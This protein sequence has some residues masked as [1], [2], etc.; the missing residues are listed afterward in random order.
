MSDQLVDFEETL[1]IG[2]EG[3]A[4]LPEKLLEWLLYPDE[5]VM[6]R[7]AMQMQ[8]D[9]LQAERD[10]LVEYVRN[11]KKLALYLVDNSNQ[12]TRKLSPLDF[13]EVEKKL[14]GYLRKEIEVGIHVLNS[15]N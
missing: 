6:E 4:R 2:I 8:N 3:E 14:P 11:L 9:L 12:V 1:E 13:S 10:E 5:W 7:E 15:A